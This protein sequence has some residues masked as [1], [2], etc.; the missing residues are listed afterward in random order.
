MRTKAISE[1]IAKVGTKKSHAILFN[2]VVAPR[3]ASPFPPMPDK[4]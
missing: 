2:Q 1:C 4:E 3:L